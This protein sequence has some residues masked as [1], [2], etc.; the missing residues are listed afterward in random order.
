MI[1]DRPQ[2]LVRRDTPGA[3][4]TFADACRTAGVGLSF[5]YPVD[6]RVQD[7]VDTLNIGQAWYPAIDTAWRHPRRRLGRRGHRTGQPE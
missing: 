7:A 5:G 4:H 1:P 2:V 6:A 3:T